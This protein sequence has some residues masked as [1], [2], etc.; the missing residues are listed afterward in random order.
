M[1]D[2]DLT[3]HTKRLQVLSSVALSAWLT[4]VVLAMAVRT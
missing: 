2:P 3:V 1:N 4:F